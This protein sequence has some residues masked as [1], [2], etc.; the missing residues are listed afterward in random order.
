MSTH[1]VLTERLSDFLALH[2]EEP[3]ALLSD[4]DP[5]FGSPL[6]VVATGSVLHGFGNER[7]DLDVNV[8]VDHGKLSTL[9]FPS[10][11]RGFLLDTLYFTASDVETW[12]ARS[13]EQGWPPEGRLERSE[14]RGRLKELVSSVRFAH[15]LP[16]RADDRWGEWL[17]DLRQ[18][19]LRERIVQWWRT[20]AQRRRLA[21]L[22]LADD[23]PR[24]ASQQWCDAALAALEARAA[25]AGQLFFGT[26]WLPEKLRKLGDGESLAVLRAALRVPLEP[27][28]AAAHAECCDAVV[29]EC[30][31]GTSSLAAQLW[32]APG[33]NR[34]A[35]RGSALVSRYDLRAVETKEALPDT[36]RSDPLWEGGIDERPPEAIRQLFVHDMT[37]MSLV[38]RRA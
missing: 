11:E 26:K 32:Y 12:A 38:A 20:E 7:S 6:L 2:G 4:I 3:E 30:A 9:S 28:A 13:R 36:G 8:V 17:E 18:P 1:T 35:L 19:W 37:W 14:W 34:R 22:W 24:L 33:V 10:F 25:M 31:G 5:S 29:D 21:A 16:L 23:K 27:G 15:G